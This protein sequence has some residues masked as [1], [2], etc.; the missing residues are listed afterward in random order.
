MLKINFLTVIFYT[1]ISKYNVCCIF[2]FIQDKDKFL[3]R[4]NSNND[5]NWVL[6]LIEFILKLTYFIVIFIFQ[7]WLELHFCGL[8]KNIMK[9][10]KNRADSD[11]KL[12]HS[13]STENEDDNSEDDDDNDEEKKDEQN[14]EIIEITKG[15]NEIETETI[16][17]QKD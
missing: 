14:E 17:D 13:Y 10:I 9:N 12:I 11:T 4:N 6:S 15:K 2:I 1:L 5:I 7:E 8:D 3:I 16:K